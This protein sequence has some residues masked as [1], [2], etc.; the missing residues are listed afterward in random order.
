MLYK[1]PFS[2]C[3]KSRPTSNEFEIVDK[4]STQYDSCS[5]W[6]HWGCGDVTKE[7]DVSFIIKLC[8]LLT[9]CKDYV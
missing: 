2:Q 7:T 3:L 6:I 5:K 9:V 8:L 1:F 4:N